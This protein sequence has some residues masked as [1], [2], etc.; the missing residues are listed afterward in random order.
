LKKILCSFCYLNKFFWQIW[1]FFF[2]QEWSLTWTVW[3]PTT[4]CPLTL[5]QPCQ[6]WW[7]GGAVWCTPQQ[8]HSGNTP[9][10]VGNGHSQSLS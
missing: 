3:V 1:Q 7:R 10:P 9:T 5:E 2:Y 4:V 8:E 6:N